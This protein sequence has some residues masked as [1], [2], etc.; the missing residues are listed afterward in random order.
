MYTPEKEAGLLSKDE[1]VEEARQP[2]AQDDNSSTYLRP[3]KCY[4]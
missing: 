3:L 2:S 4:F 1:I